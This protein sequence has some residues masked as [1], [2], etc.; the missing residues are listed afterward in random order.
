MNKQKSEKQY[1]I[2]T[3]DSFDILAIRAKMNFHK[4]VTGLMPTIIRYKGVVVSKE[5]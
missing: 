5:D 2:H 1:S 3:D 4:N